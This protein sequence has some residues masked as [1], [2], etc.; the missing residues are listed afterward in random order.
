[1]VFQVVAVEK[2]YPPP[3]TNS[4][5]TIGKGLK[6]FRGRGDAKPPEIHLRVGSK[7]FGITIN[8]VQKILFN[9]TN[10]GKNCLVI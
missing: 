4:P 5:Y 8:S 1:M 2:F 9:V 3:P 7:L 10:F 6:F